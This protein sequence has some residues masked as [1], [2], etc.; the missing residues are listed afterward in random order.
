MLDVHVAF[1]IAALSVL[2]GLAYTFGKIF[3]HLISK[4]H[5]N[6]NRS[7]TVKITA[8]NFNAH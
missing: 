5:Q 1:L 6:K 3:D 7:D 2:F 4:A 8:S